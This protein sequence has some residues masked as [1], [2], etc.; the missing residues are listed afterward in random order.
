M[1]MSKI[2]IWVVVVAVIAVGGYFVF[3]STGK[4]AEV[5]EE[6]SEVA[7]EDSSSSE[8][9]KKTA[10][11]DFMRDGG[12]YKCTVT[13][14]MSGTDSYG[15][16]YIDNDML[17][18]EFSTMVEG[19]KY[20]TNLLL[21]DGYTY[22]WSSMTPGKGIKVKNET[23]GTLTEPSAAYRFNA[24]AIGDYD[25]DAWTATTETFILPNTITFEEFGA[26]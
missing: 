8:T 4:N 14:R 22:S 3:Q 6:T 18:G 7:E 19:K 12:S 21:L 1:S 24:E 16:V 11:A 23:S 10:F 13:Q 9:G 2:V 15:V 25:C 5:A 20:D 26:Q 17:R